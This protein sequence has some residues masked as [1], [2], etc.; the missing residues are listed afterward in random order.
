[1]CVCVCVCVYGA[2]KTRF[3]CLYVYMYKC[4]VSM[5]F[6]LKKENIAAPG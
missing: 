6:F 2:Q 5:V 4:L 3:V 1:V